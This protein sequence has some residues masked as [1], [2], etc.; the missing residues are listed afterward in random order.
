MNAKLE[1][2][3]ETYFDGAKV[4]PTQLTAAELSRFTGKYRNEELDVIYTIS[5]Q[6]GKLALAIADRPPVILETI[7]K[8]VF[9]SRTGIVLTADRH[10]LGLTVY[11]QAARGMRFRKLD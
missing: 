7:S 6:D 5:I 4:Q 2:H 11:A 3:G 1:L 8:G 10:N 9:R